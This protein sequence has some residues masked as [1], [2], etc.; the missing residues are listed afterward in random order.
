MLS[1]VYFTSAREK[2]SV[3]SDDSK[4]AAPSDRKHYIPRSFEYS[5]AHPPLHIAPSMFP[6]LSDEEKAAVAAKSKTHAVRDKRALLKL[7]RAREPAQVNSKCLL[8]NG[9]QVGAACMNQINSAGAPSSKRKP[10][11]KKTKE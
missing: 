1:T 5:Q 8:A 10:S 9:S 4:K 2:M 11:I 3:S 7:V 6:V